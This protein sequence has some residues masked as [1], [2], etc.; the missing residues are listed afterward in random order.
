MTA[1]S[2]E[3]QSEHRS[4]GFP[5]R[6]IADHWR[7]AGWVMVTRNERESRRCYHQCSRRRFLQVD[8]C[9]EMNEGL[10]EDGLAWA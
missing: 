9:R 5:V 4:L 3:V 10:R 2:L 7:V 1:Q 6:S 8:S